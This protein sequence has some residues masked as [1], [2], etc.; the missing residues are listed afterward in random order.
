M[1]KKVIEGKII[2]RKSRG[3]PRR[4]Y[5]TEVKKMV[6]EHR[7]RRLKDLA[8]DRNLCQVAHVRMD[9]ARW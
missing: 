8:E 3:R 9:M 1:E 7:I 4:N 5:M 6:G 2:G